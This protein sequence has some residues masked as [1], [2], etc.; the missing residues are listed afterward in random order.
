M[1]IKFDIRAAGGKLLDMVKEIRDTFASY[2][3]T[4]VSLVLLALVGAIALNPPEGMENFLT[5]AAAFLTVFIFQELFLEEFGLHR[6]LTAAAALIAGFLAYDLTCVGFGDIEGE[7]VVALSG[8]FTIAYTT[9]L[10]CLAIWHMYRQSGLSFESYC[11]DS[12]C[13]IVRASVIYVLLS[14][15]ITSVILIFNNLIYDTDDFYGRVDVLLSGALYA[16]LLVKAISPEK[17]KHGPFAR[18]LFLYILEP[19]LMVAFLVVYIYIIKIIVKMEMPSNSV[20]AILSTMFF[21][22]L[23]IWTMTAGIEEADGLFKRLSGKIPYFFAPFIILQLICIGQRMAE[24]GITCPR[25][26]GLTLIAFEII[27]MLLYV[28]KRDKISTTPVIAGIILAISLCAPFINAW[29]VSTSSQ[30]GRLDR[31]AAGEK[32][33]TAKKDMYMLYKDI[34][35]MGATSK[36]SLKKHYSEEQIEEF[37]SYYTATDDFYS[38]VESVNIGDTD[39]DYSFCIEG[40]KRLSSV[41]CSINAKEEDIDTKKLE[42]EVAA[43]GETTLV[44]LSELIEGYMEEYDHE[45]Q[46]KFKNSCEVI[47][48]EDGRGLYIR[49]FHMEFG[50]N[51]HEI[52]SLTVKGYL[53]EK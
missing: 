47:S 45:N 13:A 38:P 25:Y 30:L 11:M 50:K 3:V 22:G 31:M 42:F 27:Y 52:S 7:L 4:L 51:N 12:F 10:L 14:I 36:R 32:T 40:Y 37:E 26:F 6:A 46:H 8:R 16:P 34:Y 29:S 9:L 18:F 48:L 5:K 43:G 15:G 49:E 35:D 19:V 2:P 21:T 53:L 33:D 41:S 24:Y 1:E 28:F 39:F 20:F 23:P 44:D 17:E